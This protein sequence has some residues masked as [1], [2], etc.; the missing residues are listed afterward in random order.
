MFFVLIVFRGFW[1]AEVVQ[2]VIQMLRKQKMELS[3]QEIRKII[4]RKI[5]FVCPKLGGVHL[6][7]CMDYSSFLIP[8]DTIK[9]ARVW[10][11]EDIRSGGD[12]DLLEVE[13]LKNGDVKTVYAGWWEDYFY[14]SKIRRWHR[15]EKE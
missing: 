9:E 1:G 6:P 4:E 2:D 7:L 14:V 11:M 12:R 5:W 3:V 15:K 13:V 10:A 8:A